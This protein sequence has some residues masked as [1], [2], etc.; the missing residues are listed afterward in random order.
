MPTH[1]RNERRVRQIRDTRG[2]TDEVPRKAAIDRPSNSEVLAAHR[3]MVR[4]IANEII[5]P[6]AGPY[7]KPVI[8]PIPAGGAVVLRATQCE[9]GKSLVDG[10]RVE[11]GDSKSRVAVDPVRSSSIIR[12]KDSAVVAANQAVRASP[13]QGVDV[14]V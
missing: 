5:G 14:R 3:L 8:P 2:D 11:R 12:V 13:R 9:R 1:P 4:V 10:P 6:I 7:P